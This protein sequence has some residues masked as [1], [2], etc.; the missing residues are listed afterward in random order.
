MIITTAQGQRLDRSKSKAFSTEILSP[1]PPEVSEFY[2]KFE[3]GHKK[4]V[5]P[6]EVKILVRLQAFSTTTIYQFLIPYCKVNNLTEC[7]S[8]SR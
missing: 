1:L 7:V 8:Q 4:N 5:K 3:I 2:K 6:D